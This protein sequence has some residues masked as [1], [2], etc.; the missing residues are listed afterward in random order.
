MEG[1]Q[2][3]NANSG[4][5]GGAFFVEGLASLRVNNTNV[6]AVQSAQGKMIYSIANNVTKVELIKN[7]MRCFD[8]YLYDFILSETQYNVSKEGSAIYMSNNGSI[9]SDS[10]DFSNCFDAVSGSIFSLSQS[11]LDDKSSNFYSKLDLIKQN[12]YSF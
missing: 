4:A 9:S 3:R 7:S 10:N 8:S 11:S 5:R 2:I 12:I 1:C 6:T